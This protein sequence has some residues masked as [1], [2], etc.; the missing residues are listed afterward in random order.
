MN[1]QSQDT[2]ECLIRKMNKKIKGSEKQKQTRKLLENQKYPL[3]HFDWQIYGRSLSL[4]YAFQF[5]KSLSW[6]VSR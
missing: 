6:L 1:E 5:K 2:F 3:G 4:S